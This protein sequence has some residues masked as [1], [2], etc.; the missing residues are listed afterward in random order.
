MKEVVTECERLG[1]FAP[2]KGS[3]VIEFGEN[4]M[5]T[6]FFARTNYTGN[7]QFVDCEKRIHM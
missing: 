5:P 6:G 3:Q 1:S 7:G 2:V 4:I